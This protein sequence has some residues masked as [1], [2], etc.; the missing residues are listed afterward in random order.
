MASENLKT[1][2]LARELFAEKEL[3]ERVQV[4][5]PFPM[6]LKNLPGI[7]SLGL[8]PEIYF[9]AGVL[10]SLSQE[11]VQKT[12]EELSR[13]NIPVTIHAPFMDLS[14]GAGDRKIRQV[15]ALRFSQVLNLVPYFHPRAIIFHGGYDR[16][17]FDG[18]VSLWL[19]NSLLTWK[20]LVDRAGT[21]SVQ[22]ALE[23]VFEENPSHLKRLLDTIESPYLGYCLDAGHGYLFSEVPIVDWIEDLASRLVEVHLHDNHRQADEHLPIGYG[24][25]DFGGIFSSLQAK[26]L[27]PIYTIEPHT[28]EGL[29]PSLRALRKYL[30]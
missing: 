1:A 19:E 29:L 24:E 26:N 21:H 23:N 20:P 9:D 6:L 13:K 27:H 18:D 30:R 2:N 16:W 7:T 11:E 25:I 8:R 15:T 17:R 22:L 5:L 10:D 4:N 3:I 14:P 12:S 28:E